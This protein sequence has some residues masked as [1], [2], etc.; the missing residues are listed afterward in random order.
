MIADHCGG[1]PLLAFVDVGP[2]MIGENGEPKA[3][4]FVKDRLHMN[5]AG[6]AL[7]TSE[8]RPAVEKLVGAYY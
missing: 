6:Y 3:D 8:I 5:P 2:V 4:I 7:W 1:D